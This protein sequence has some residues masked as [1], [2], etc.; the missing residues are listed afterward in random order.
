MK[1]DFLPPHLRKYISTQDYSKYTPVDQAV[2]RYTLRQ[3]KAFLIVHAEESYVA[4]LEKTGIGTDSIPRIED[5]SAKIEK[6]GWRAMPVSGFIPP[7]AFMELQSL[8]VLPIASDMRTMDHLLYTPAPDIVHE[9]AGHAPILIHPEFAEYLRRYAQ[10]AKKAI[11]SK[12]DLDLYEAIRDL[13]DIKENPSSTPDNVK[14][15]EARLDKVS[16]SMSHISEAAELGRMNWWTAEYG[17]IGDLNDP[18]IFGAGLLSSIGEA[19]WCLSEKV[20]KIPL[21]VEC[22]K[23]GYD[24]TEPQPQLF[25]TPD[26]ETLTHVLEEM[27]SQMAFRLGGLM[28]LSKAIEAKSVNTAELNSGVQISGVVSGVIS[29]ADETVAY[30]KFQGPTQLSYLDKEIS[31]H[32]KEYHAHGF[33]TPVGAFKKFPYSCPSCLTT[34]QWKELGVAVGAT[35]QLDYVSG[36]VISGTIKGLLQKAGKSLILS[37]ENASAQYQDQTL[38]QPSWG[39]YDV[40]LGLDVRS[41]FGSPADREAY[42]ETDDFVAKKVPAAKY[43]DHELQMHNQYQAVRYLREKNIDGE[44]LQTALKNILDKHDEQF[45]DDWLLRVEIHE[46]LLKNKINGDLEKRILASFKKIGNA[47]EKKQSLIADGLQLAGKI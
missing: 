37:L 43:S 31:G 18:K 23:Q 22:I 6:F 33:G 14:A 32:H 40:A 15:A 4:G 46:L 30:L 35:V 28:G 45:P 39:T 27:A 13:S 5:I 8:G 41:V 34:E 47:S 44:N 42:G 21:T 2:W 19:R 26:F 25:V 1:T 16:K 36:V 24:I 17:L 11:I 9:A 38:F 3:L 10:I 12:E 20:K 7:A 29:L